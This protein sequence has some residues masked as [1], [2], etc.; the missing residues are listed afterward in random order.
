MKTFSA[1]P[2]E[3]PRR[4]WVV[5]AEGKNLGRLSTQIAT[6]LRG[7]NK[8]GYTPHVDTGD[9]VVV[10]NAEKVAVTGTKLQ[11]K[12][13][14]RHSGYPGGLRMRTLSEMLERRPGEVIRTSVKGMLPKNRL[15]A[16]QLS[17][18]K[19][20]AGPEHPHAAQKP[21]EMTWQA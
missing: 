10:V 8:P 14:Y 18:L 5:D 12:K 16:K 1:K 2:G 19:I 17:K 9:F 6:V 15:A 11:S 13:Y 7:K 3:V 4:W 21:E 20:Y